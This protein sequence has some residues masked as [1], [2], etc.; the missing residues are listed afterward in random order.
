MTRLG[1]SAAAAFVVWLSFGGRR[2]EAA[3]EAEHWLTAGFGTT[4]LLGAGVI[5]LFLTILKRAARERA[6][7]EA[8]LAR[9]SQA[10]ETA[11]AALAYAPALILYWRRGQP[12]A[13]LINRLKSSLAPFG[14]L[15][16]RRLDDLAG[17]LDSKDFDELRGRLARL[18]PGDTLRQTCY[19]ADGG[20]CFEAAAV[21][22]DQRI[23]LTLRDSTIEVNTLSRLEAE[24]GAQR[25]AATG[26]K[27]VAD[28]ISI[29]MWRRDASLSLVWCNPAYAAVGGRVTLGGRRDETSVIIW[30]ADTGVGIDREE[31]NNVFRRFHRGTSPLARQTGAGLGLSLVRY[32]VELHGGRLQLD[33]QAEVGT[34]VTCYFPI[35][36]KA[37]PD[38]VS[39][40]VP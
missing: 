8:A 24:V 21:A 4:A 13:E 11:R 14:N 26:L 22:D 32:F 9:L 18:E 29:P 25:Q 7:H 5:I 40:F 30:V 23:C 37:N 20:K 28:A 38:T 34:T 3:W 6:A 36:A 10:N 17:Q 2:A 1:K 15:V 16:V 19:S 39:P 27:A 31:Q 35:E 12:E 33:S